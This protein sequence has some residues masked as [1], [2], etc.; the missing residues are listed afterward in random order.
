MLAA[1]DVLYDD[2]APCSTEPHAD[3]ARDARRRLGLDPSGFVAVH[4]GR[5]TPSSGID[6]VILA[7]ALLRFHHAIDAT[8]LI[9]DAAGDAARNPA[10]AERSRLRQLARELGIEARVHFLVCPTPA[11]C[12]HCYAASNVLVDMPWQV[13]GNAAVLEAMSSS[14][15]VIGVAGSGVVDGVT[16]WLV[17]PR[18]AR[19]LAE[20]LARLQHS[21]GL[22]ATMGAAGRSWV[23][24]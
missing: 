8:L 24:A 16:G 5:M 21:P 11:A 4:C 2:S 3:P 20:R 17:A 13:Q 14:R 15:P 18:D 10:H 9:V 6:T 23:A 7:I 19:M 1:D 22:A 12:T